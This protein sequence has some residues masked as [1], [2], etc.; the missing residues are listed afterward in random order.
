VEIGPPDDAVI[1]AVLIK[2]F[3]DRQLKVGTEVVTYLLRHM[4][5]SFQAMRAL[6]DAAD[7]VSLAEQ[8]PITVPLVRRLLDGDGGED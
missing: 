5:R 2:L 8:R 1:A 4:E 3:A 7:A 6:V